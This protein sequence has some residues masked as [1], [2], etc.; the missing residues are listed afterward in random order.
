MTVIVTTQLHGLPPEGYDASAAHLAA[1][2][3]DADG[4]IAHAATVDPD[5]V[6]V[7]ELWRSAD[8]WQRFF[9]AHVKPSLPAE[10]PPPAIVEA[11][12]T[13]LR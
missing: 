9:D 6:T 1:P 12:N 5:G 13:I 4:F 8:D 3:R 2:L 11:R 7:T 10:L